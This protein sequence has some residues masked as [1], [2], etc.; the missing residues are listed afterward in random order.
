MKAGKTRLTRQGDAKAEMSDKA[1]AEVK[2]EPRLKQAIQ[3]QG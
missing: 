2:A 1:D 3:R